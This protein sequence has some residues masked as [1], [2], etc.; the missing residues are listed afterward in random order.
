M[1]R[2]DSWA[3]HTSRGVSGRARDD[4]LA[5]I[6]LCDLREPHPTERG[7]LTRA[8]NVPD[9]DAQPPPARTLSHFVPV[10]SV[11]APHSKRHRNLPQPCLGSDGT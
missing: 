5:V 4:S 1:A 10:P 8:R 6:L 9:Q 11:S 3:A 2:L 7:S